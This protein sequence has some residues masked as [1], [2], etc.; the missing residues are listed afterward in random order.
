M[1]HLLATAGSRKVPIFVWDKRVN[2]Y[3]CKWQV[4]IVVQ[5]FDGDL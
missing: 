3:A 5:L 2:L 1:P 4:S